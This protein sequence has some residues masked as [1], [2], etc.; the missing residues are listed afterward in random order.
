[1]EPVIGMLIQDITAHPRLFAG[2]SFAPVHVGELYMVELQKH[3][4]R[5]QHS[6]PHLMPPQ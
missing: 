5:P 6:K 3:E 2:D 1:M 4:F